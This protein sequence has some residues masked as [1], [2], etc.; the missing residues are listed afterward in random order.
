[1][2]YPSLVL[3]SACSASV[4]LC[5]LREWRVF[6]G[7]IAVVVAIACAAC[8]ITA[9]FSGLQGG[10][11]LPPTPP[12]TSS[13]ASR[14]PVPTFCDDFDHEPLPGVWDV[15]HQVGGSLAIDPGAH[16]SAPSSLVARFAALTAGQLLDTTLRK[17]L[18]LPAAPGRT[19]FELAVQPVIVD[20]APGAVIV[21]Y[22]VDFLDAAKNRYTLQL[23]LR[24]T[25]GELSVT[26]GEQSGFVDGGMAYVEHAL[27]DPLTVGRW[28]KIRLDVTRTAPQ[29]ATAR[30]T[31]DG[32]VELDAV[33][34]QV[35]VNATSIVAALG[36][37]FESLP[38][39]EWVIRYDDVVVDLTP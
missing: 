23:T 35:T 34:L 18:A 27:A 36:S 16:V 1:M 5:A 39:K 30:L 4:A 32:R 28:T 26:L 37:T 25:A 9:D 22:A 33:A 8:G 14:T 13:C 12:P 29:A 10:A 17:R 11:P 15:F 7:V 2:A 3:S 24:Q 20:A 21:I 6:A 31:F 38:S 19:T